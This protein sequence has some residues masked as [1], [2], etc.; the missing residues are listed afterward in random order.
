MSAMDS[1]L[2]NRQLRNVGGLARAKNATS[3]P[4][5]QLRKPESELCEW[6]GTSLP[7]RQLRKKADTNAD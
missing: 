7:N 6:D 2:P 1:S 4:N 3:L 5:R